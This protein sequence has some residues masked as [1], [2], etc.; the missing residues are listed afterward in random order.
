MEIADQLVEVMFE[1]EPLAATLLGIPGYDERLA[2]PS[3]TAG[4]AF[5]AKFGDIAT[6]ARSLDPAQLD[7]ADRVTRGVVIQQAEA[8]VDR[9]ATRSVEYTVTDMFFAPVAE[10]LTL[11]PMVAVTTAEQAE[12]YLFRLGGIP[13]FLTALA[14]RHRA[15][16]AAGRS[17]VAHLVEAA[18]AQ[19]DRYLADPNYDPFL[20]P[21]LSAGGQKFADRRQQILTDIVRPAFASY[22]DVLRNEVLQHGRTAQQPGLCALP[23]GEQAYALMARSHTTTDRSAAELHQIGRDLIAKL[24]EEYIE[25]GSRIF[26]PLRLTEIFQRLRTDPAL[27]W[28]NGDELLTT[29]RKAVDRAEE[30]TPQW[31]GKLPAQRCV[32]EAIPAVEAPGAAAGYYLL[33]SLDSQRPGTYFVNTDRPRERFRYMAEALAFHEAVPGH[34]FQ[35][36]LAQELTGLPLL[37]RIV[38]VTAYVEGWAL[39]TERLADEMGLYS[40]DVA[41]LG[42]LTMDSM[43]AARLVVDTGIHAM[44]WSR[45]RAVDYMRDNTA[46]AQ[47]EI[48]TEV[49]RYIAGPGQALAY[50]VGR[51]EIERLRTET[52]QVLGERFDIRAFHDVVL[53]GGAL[54]L[55]VLADVVASWAS[56]AR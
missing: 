52:A 6:R 8:A 51:L 42:M 33:P 9:I 46:M 2:D 26:G 5:A 23:G 56:A 21:H 29:A 15:G 34:H 47:V 41:R 37:R 19:L 54:P 18:A 31:F 25:I 55:S 43:R 48:D 32:I 38:M 7:E 53:G 39:Y 36:S 20:R 10:L 24:A 28:N 4:Q 16:I 14:Q 13:A 1:V 44:G 17:P 45:Q 11:L 49:D 50:M 35:T 12:A 22:R 27:R 40:D 30:A 3:E